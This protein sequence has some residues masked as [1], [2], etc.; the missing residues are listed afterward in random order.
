MT[1]SDTKNSYAFAQIGKDLQLPVTVMM[2][3]SYFLDDIIRETV[4][5]V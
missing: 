5:Q 1:W 2:K 4:R 3:V